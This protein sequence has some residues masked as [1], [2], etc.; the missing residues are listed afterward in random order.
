ML[1]AI[2]QYVTDNKEWIFSGVGVAIIVAVAGLFFRKK[3]DI[4]QTIKSGSSSTNIQAG[5]DVH[6]NNDQK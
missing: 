3:S 6:I 4:N 2:I 1:D 5:Q